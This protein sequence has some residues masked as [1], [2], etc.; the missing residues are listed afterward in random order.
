MPTGQASGEVTSGDPYRLCHVVI[1]A[2]LA[3]VEIVPPFQHQILHLAPPGVGPRFAKRLYGQIAERLLTQGVVAAQA[4]LAIR[5]HGHLE[6]RVGAA[7]TVGRDKALAIRGLSA[8]AALQFVKPAL[9]D[10]H[11][12]GEIRARGIEMA[13]D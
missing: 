12:A 10:E 8:A 7:A 5:P 1:V 2:M 11:F 4:E 9:L 3:D 6:E 13:D